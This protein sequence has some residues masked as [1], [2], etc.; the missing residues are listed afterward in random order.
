VTTEVVLSHT[1]RCSYEHSTESYTEN[2]LFGPAEQ[3]NNQERLEC[4]EARTMRRS[5]DL[6]LKA[7]HIEH[8][9]FPNHAAT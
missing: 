7:K 9:T 5:Y 4:A 8:E 3:Q 1:E 2:S 6:S